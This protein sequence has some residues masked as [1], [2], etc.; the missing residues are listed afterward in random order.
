MSQNA[1][2]PLWVSYLI[3]FGPLIVAA[4]VGYVA[5]R[6]WKTAHARLRLDLFDR[7]YRIYEA[8][9]K[10]FS[11]IVRE[12]EVKKLI[13]PEFNRARQEADFFFGD[14]VVSRLEEFDRHATNLW[15]LEKE[16]EG[17]IT[18]DKKKEIAREISDDL[19]W[20]FDEF[21]NTRDIFN[22]YMRFSEK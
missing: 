2:T 8:Y 6:Q 1:Q 10:R 18:Q 7:R 3:A 17:P 12:G 15:R 21:K 16:R 4:L 9:W 19:K 11:D 14:D 22:K 13:E 5:Y 20:K